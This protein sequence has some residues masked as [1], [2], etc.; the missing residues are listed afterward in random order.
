MILYIYCLVLVRSRKGF[1]KDFKI[2]L[3][4]IRKA[5][6]EDLMIDLHLC[7]ISSLIIYRRKST[8][9]CKCCKHLTKIHSF[10]EE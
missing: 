10:L 3:K 6:T 9:K 4:L 8:E 5:N 2:K 7:K 1:K